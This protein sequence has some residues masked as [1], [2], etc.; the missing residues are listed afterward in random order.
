[1]CGVANFIVRHV[2]G[3]AAGLLH[4]LEGIKAV[5]R[6]ANGQRLCNRVRLHRLEEVEACLLRGGNRRTAGRLRAMH[7]VGALGRESQFDELLIALLHFRK[8]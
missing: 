2:F 4:Y 3:R 7:L 1:M 5:C 8:Q 6:R